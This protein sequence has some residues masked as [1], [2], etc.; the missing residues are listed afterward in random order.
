MCCKKRDLLCFPTI[1]MILLYQHIRL[2]ICAC[3][4]AFFSSLR[5]TG[6]IFGLRTLRAFA[7][8]A[9]MRFEVIILSLELC[10]NLCECAELDVPELSLC[11]ENVRAVFRVNIL[12]VAY[13][14]LSLLCVSVICGA[15]PGMCGWLFLF[16]RFGQDIHS[17]H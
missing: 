5:N 15:L 10:L 17:F 2:T 13:H 9:R 1:G 4:F 12:N 14:V 16:Q 8:L 11:L 6:D 3:F 7:Y